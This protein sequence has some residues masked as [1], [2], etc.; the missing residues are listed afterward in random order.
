MINKKGLCKECNDD[1]EKI[2][3][4]KTHMLCLKHNR[5]RLD[6]QNL[7]RKTKTPIRPISKKMEQNNKEY[8]RVRENK[9]KWQK[10]KG[11]YKCVFCNKPLDDDKDLI[12]CH[13]MIG[14]DGDRLAEWKNLF[15]AHRNHHSEYHHEKDINRLMKTSW[16]PPF[17]ERL[18]ELNPK[19]YNL[20]LKR[21]HK[22]GIIDDQQYFKMYIP[23]FKKE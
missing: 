2:I 7:K 4:N 14:R 18:R 11:Y 9:R 15:F 1:I 20:E 12:D 21:M 6:G 17:F 16:Y 3:V 13:H 8:I 19:V 10:E 22:G 5:E 23:I